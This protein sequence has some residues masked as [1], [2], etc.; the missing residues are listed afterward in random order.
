MPE[1]YVR[2][3]GIGSSPQCEI[4]KKLLD[5]R[6]MIVEPNKGHFI[7]ELS[8]DYNPR[9]GMLESDNSRP[10]RMFETGSNPEYVAKKWIIKD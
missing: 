1:E 9:T 3:K 5:L 4:N 2:Y 8:Q 6:N 10:V 7:P